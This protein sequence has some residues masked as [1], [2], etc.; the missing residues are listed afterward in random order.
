MLGLFI[1]K[2][3]F[4]SSVVGDDEETKLSGG[5]DKRKGGSASHKPERRKRREHTDVA[6]VLVTCSALQLP[7]QCI[8]NITIERI[9]IA[10][11][12]FKS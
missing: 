10:A 1:Y 6:G 11:S 12:S 2:L 8:I 7:C 5:G 9:T 4:S 3:P